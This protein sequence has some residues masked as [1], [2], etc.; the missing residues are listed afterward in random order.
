[1]PDSFEQRAMVELLD[2][3]QH[4][5]LSC[6]TAIALYGTPGFALEPI[7][8]SRGRRGGRSPRRG[9]VWHHPRLL[10]DHHVLIVNGL[11]TTTPARTLADLGGLPGIH[12]NRVVRAINSA[13]AGGLV[14]RAQLERMADEWCERGRRGSAFLHEYLDSHA[15]DWKPPASNIANRFIQIVVDAGMPE[16]LSEV[17]IGD[18]ERWLGRVDC[19]DPEFPLIAEIDSDRFHVAPLDA[20]ADAHRDV[21]MGRAGFAVIRFPEHKVWHAPQEV[22]AEWRAARLRARRRLS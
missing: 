22:V 9:V 11:R 17:N 10:P 6:V 19:L 5:A 3:G 2:A 15:P 20:E 4:S 16:P 13:W 1:V 7:H 14:T 18:S 12:P 8:I 21:S